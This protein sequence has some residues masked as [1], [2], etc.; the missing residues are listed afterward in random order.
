MKSII[1]FTL[2]LLSIVLFNACSNETESYTIKKGSITEALYAS[3]SIESDDQYQV[4]PIVSG[5]IKQILV[6]EGSKIQIGDTL[7]IIKND[8][9]RINQDNA[10]L[11]AEFNSI[12]NNQ[13]KIDELKLAIN[14]AKDKFSYDSL[15]FAKQKELY[16]R[17]IISESEY[18]SSELNF[19]TSKNNYKSTELQLK[20]TI[21]QLEFAAK[22]SRNQLSSSTVNNSD[23]I[24]KSTINGVVYS[25]LKNKGEFVSPQTTLAV[26]GSDKNF[27]IELQIDEVDITKVIKNQQVFIELDSYKGQV[28]EA[29]ISKINPIMNERTKSF[30]VEAIFKKA[31]PIL[32]PNLTL[33]ANIVVKKKDNTIVIP[34]KYLSPNNE[35][36]L[37]DGTL[38]KVKTG[39][40]DYEKIEVLDHLKENQKIILPTNE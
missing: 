16:K 14:K 33:E 9:S 23:F 10:Q 34:R 11:N 35:V 31:P 15:M 17:S 32:Y 18:E 5:I 26:V 3:G 27:K 38:V 2:L 20:N 36:T 19:N 22:Q 6:D 1:T 13:T 30:T 37:E 4:Q 8:A 39:L 40:K 28:F 12:A 7:I 29:Y 24:I 21:K 25:I